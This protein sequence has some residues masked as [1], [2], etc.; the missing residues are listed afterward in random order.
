MEIQYNHG[1]PDFS[2]LAGVYAAAVTPLLADGTI[3][4][5]VVSDLLSFLQ[6]RGCHG[7]LLFGTTGEGPSFSS[8]ERLEM[9][10]AAAAFR[11]TYPEFRLLA[12]TGTPS[13]EDT[14]TLTQAAFETGVDGVVVLPPYYYR[15]VS[16]AGLYAWFS[17]VLERAVPDGKVLL[18][19]HIPPVTGVGLSIDLLQR[20]RE[21]FPGRFAGIKDSSA[22]P[23]HALHLGDHFGAGLLVLNG[24]DPLFSLALQNGA[25]GCITALANL[26]SP[27]LRRIWDAHLLEEADVEAQAQMLALRA[28]LDRYP[29]A[30]ALLKAMLARQHGLPRWSVRPP[31]LPLDADLEAQIAG[32]F[33]EAASLQA[34][35]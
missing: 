11:Q 15:N 32:E 31:L 13:L 1:M 9:L 21:D 10:N 29:P 8:R 20:L 3:D 6:R 28:V 18:G 24:N 25:A 35:G 14:I 7:A 26:Y 27:I 5:D 34:G 2:H 12:G 4:L 22:S 23:E 17:Q 19:Y 30:P 16:D 33:E